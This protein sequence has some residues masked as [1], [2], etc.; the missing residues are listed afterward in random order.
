MLIVLND[1]S[2]EPA[3]RGSWPGTSR[4]VPK[5]REGIVQE[6]DSLVAGNAPKMDYEK[7]SGAGV[8]H[9]P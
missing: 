7:A 3:A 4:E 9:P 8:R 2:L 6:G 5:M 1:L